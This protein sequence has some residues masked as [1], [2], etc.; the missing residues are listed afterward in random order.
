MTRPSPLTCGPGSLKAKAMNQSKFTENDGTLIGPVQL[1]ELGPIP[2]P[3][4]IHQEA[5]AHPERKIAQ[6]PRMELGEVEIKQ[7]ITSAMI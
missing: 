2:D 5:T 3:N 1:P 7:Q 4:L 6:I